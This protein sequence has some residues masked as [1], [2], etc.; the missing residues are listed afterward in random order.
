[1]PFD[2]LLQQ[3]PER[4]TWLYWLTISP[5]RRCPLLCAKCRLDLQMSSGSIL[6]LTGHSED[7][8]R[9]VERI[10]KERGLVWSLEWNVATHEDEGDK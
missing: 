9:E 1:M 8:I 2:E 7:E 6:D 10:L 3:M 4:E 5:C